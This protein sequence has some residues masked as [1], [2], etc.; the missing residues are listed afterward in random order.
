MKK[1][2]RRNTIL[3]VDPRGQIEEELG[4]FVR[5]PRPRNITKQFLFQPISPVPSHLN[6]ESSYKSLNYLPPMHDSLKDLRE[7]IHI[8]FRIF[9]RPILKRQISLP[10]RLC[11][12]FE[13]WIS[14]SSFKVKYG[15]TSCS[16]GS[17]RQERGTPCSVQREE[18][19]F[20]RRVK[21]IFQAHF[22]LSLTND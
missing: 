3:N 5:I 20:R 12:F 19:T 21:A 1:T 17:K 9:F 11:P 7:A 10:Y 14:A 6:N 2:G 22:L 13:G 4:E 15:R 16:L 8:L 18:I